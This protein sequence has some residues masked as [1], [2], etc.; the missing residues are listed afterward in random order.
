MAVANTKSTYIGNADAVP[1]VLTS[2]YLHGSRL[3]HS[4]ATVEI[5]AADDN[6]SV[7]RM[8]RLP[9]NAIVT[10]IEVMNDA[11]TGGTDY[12][13]GLYD[14]LADGSAV[15]DVNAYGDAIDMSSA[16]T[17]PLDVSFEILDIDK[18]EKRLFE[19]L[20]LS[21]DSNQFYDLCYTGVVVGTAAGTL[22]M[23]VTYSL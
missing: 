15:V 13:I 21:A 11:I 16:R 12:D 14:T 23:R 10:R 17:L 3:R 2:G 7:Y 5:L 20:G 18:V 8:V 22:T 1:P 4:T 9:S 6:N 19:V